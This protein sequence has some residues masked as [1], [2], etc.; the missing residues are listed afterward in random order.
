MFPS[1]C[2][3]IDQAIRGNCRCLRVVLTC[4]P[5]LKLVFDKARF[6]SCVH[7][8]GWQHFD[9]FVCR[10]VNGFKCIS[11][12]ESFGVLPNSVGHERFLRCRD[13][14][15]E[16]EHHDIQSAVLMYRRKRITL[17]R[18]KGRNLCFVCPCQSHRVERLIHRTICVRQQSPRHE[19][20]DLLLMCLSHVVIHSCRLALAAP[21]V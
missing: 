21:Q 2:E 14:Q 11:L 15:P 3:N 6:P 9:S 1:P 7:K 20:L 4:G 16:T 5:G 17:L 18:S 13:P 8:T 10:T 12:F 19:D